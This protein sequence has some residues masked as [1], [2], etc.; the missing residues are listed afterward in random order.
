MNRTD[1]G[2]EKVIGAKFLQT[3]GGTDRSSAGESGNA[4]DTAVCQ[5]SEVVIATESLVAQEDVSRLESL[6]LLAEQR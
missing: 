1:P 4:V 2:D 3:S 6:S 5:S